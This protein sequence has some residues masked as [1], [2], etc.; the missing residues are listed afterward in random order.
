MSHYPS[1]RALAFVAWS[2]ASCVQAAQDH[3]YKDESKVPP[4]VLPEV[5]TTMD[6]RTM[7]TAD[8]WIQT[9]RPEILRIYEEHVFG[10]TPRQLPEDLT[11]QTVEQ[12]PQ[13]LNGLAHRKQVEIRFPAHPNAPVLHLLVYTPAKASVPVPTFICLHFSRNWAVVDDPGVRLYERWDAKTKTKVM[14]EPDAKRGTAKEWDIPLVLSRGYGIAVMHYGDIEPDW[15]DGSGIDYGVRSLYRSPGTQGRDPQEW[16][17]IGAWAWG[18]SRAVDYLVADPQVDRARI[19]GFGQSRLGKTV[20]WAGAQDTRLA[21]IIASCSGEGGAAL[22]RRDYGENLDNMT[23]TYLY[24]FCDG[25]RNYYQNWAALPVDAHHLLA[26]LAPRPILLNV[27]QTDWWSDPKGEFLAAQA[28][29]PVYRLFGK[30]GLEQT[31]F[32]KAGQPVLRDLG[33]HMHS[34]GHTVLRE[35]WKVFLDAADR[36]FR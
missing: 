33:F 18:M 28:A 1:L 26:L 22:S 2:A 8:D 27:G 35:D 7:R 4:Y 3:S 5:L 12:D 25:F 6:G 31:E 20:L 30:S 15:G 32:P 21:M 16:G 9:R 10:R 19:I 29:S 17:A 36:A 23:S 24:Q 13:A 14:A 34:A 11:I